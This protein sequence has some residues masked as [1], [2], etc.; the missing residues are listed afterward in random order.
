MNTSN[1]NLKTAADSP[2]RKCAKRDRCERSCFYF[3]DW[4]RGRKKKVRFKNG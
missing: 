3:K 4:A 2:C 1:K